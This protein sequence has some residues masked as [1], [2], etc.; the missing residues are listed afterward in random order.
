MIFGR[1]SDLGLDAGVV[2]FNFVAASFSWALLTW[3]LP[4]NLP[5]F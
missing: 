4:L 1:R 2:V 3:Q 5:A